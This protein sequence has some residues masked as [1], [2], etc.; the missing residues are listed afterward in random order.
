MRDWKQGRQRTQDSWQASASNYRCWI[1]GAD[2]APSCRLELEGP[3]RRQHVALPARVQPCAPMASGV[4]K[5]G[6]RS[7]NDGTWGIPVLNLVGALWAQGSALSAQAPD[8]GPGS[9][10]KDERMT[11]TFDLG[12]RSTSN[13]IYS[14]CTNRHWTLFARLFA[15]FLTLFTRAAPAKSRIPSHYPS[16]QSH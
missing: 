9:A 3:E 12:S 14:L 16:E 8:I 15:R 7:L 10:T 11:A 5:P 1:S 13:L 4:L 2:L 6:P